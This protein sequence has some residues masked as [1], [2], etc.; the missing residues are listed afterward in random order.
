M[1]LC[2]EY[3]RNY[4]CSITDYQGK[5][6]DEKLGDSEWELQRPLE[7][8]TDADIKYSVSSS[9]GQHECSETSLRWES[10]SDV[11]LEYRF[12]EWKSLSKDILKN[13]KP[14]GP[15]IDISVTNGTLREVQLPHFV[16]VDSVS[17][18]DDA[19]KVLHVKDGTVS[20]ERCE[21]SGSHAKIL[22]PT[23]SCVA[24]VVEAQRY[25]NM[26]FQCET[27]IYR[28]RK[29][30]LNLHVYLIV[31]DQKLKKCLF[32]KMRQHFVHPGAEFV[33][34]HR[35]QLIRKVSLVEP[36]ADDMK[37]LIGDEKYGMISMSVTKEEKMRTLLNFL[38]TPKLKDKLY[39]SL[40]EHEY[41][42]IEYLND[43]G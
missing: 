6:T 3:E 29:A 35:T 25:N 17:S 36:I 11:S 20:F 28:N 8:K 38:T 33:D 42:V 24:I 39:Q 9:A 14:C 15:L 12:V 30:S 10:A 23:F 40:V 1:K 4:N 7:V 26:K 34:K 2:E 5:K 31:K 41:H 16:C 19:V 27:L 32:V 13:Y 18:S 21:L 43:S 37:D 22:N